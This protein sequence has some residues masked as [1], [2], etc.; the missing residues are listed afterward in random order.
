MNLFKSAFARPAHVRPCPTPVR[1][2]ARSLALEVQTKFHL[3]KEDARLLVASA[4]ERA[5]KD[6]D[7]AAEL[8]RAN[9]ANLCTHSKSGAP[10]GAFRFQ[11]AGRPPAR[12]GVS[13][14]KPSSDDAA[15]ASAIAAAGGRSGVKVVYISASSSSKR[16]LNASL[17]SPDKTCRWW[18]HKTDKDYSR[19]TAGEELLFVCAVKAAEGQANFA[20]SRE[21][22]VSQHW[23]A[24]HAMRAVVQ[25]AWQ[26]ADGEDAPWPDAPGP[27][28]H[29]A[30]HS[31][32]TAA[33]VAGSF[34][35][36]V[37]VTD[38]Q[39][40]A[41]FDMRRLPAGAVNAARLSAIG[42]S[43]GQGAGKGCGVLRAVA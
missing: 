42:V 3:S 33:V 14:G 43:N 28:A 4:F 36:R 17:R 34:G 27:A 29:T 6:I 37:Q 2:R 20:R 38:V 16:N 26:A 41:N 30:P 10:A 15:A 22:D 1:S 35:F 40:C 23:V 8:L 18:G 9:K 32:H 19:L 13:K 11:P 24:G 7:G 21:E 25:R 31:T 5:G 12:Q 39:S